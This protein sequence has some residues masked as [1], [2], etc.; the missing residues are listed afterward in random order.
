MPEEG[1]RSFI[2]GCGPPCGCW[3]LNSDPLEEQPVLLRAELPLQPT[4]KR[5]TQ[6]DKGQA[7]SDGER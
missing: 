1:I 5:F 7:E 4:E 2:D 6:T 3:E